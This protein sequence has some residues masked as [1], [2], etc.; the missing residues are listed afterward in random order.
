MIQILNNIFDSL[1]NSHNIILNFDGLNIINIDVGVSISLLLIFVPVC[2]IA[3]MIFKLLNL[4][5]GSK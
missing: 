4:F 3:F 5:I 2:Y 1:F